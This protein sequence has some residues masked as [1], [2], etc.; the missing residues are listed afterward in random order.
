MFNFFQPQPEVTVEEIHAEFDSAEK[1]VLDEV[2]ELLNELKIPT[3]DKLERKAL[4]LK[5]LGFENTE[6]VKQYELFKKNQKIITEKIELSKKQAEL[7]RDFKFK[8]P[9]EKFITTIELE[10]ICEKY[11]LIHAPAVNYKKDIPEKN[12]LEMYKRKP[13]LNGDKYPTDFYIFKAK[14]FNSNSIYKKQLKGKEFLI[15]LTDYEYKEVIKN[16]KLADNI[17]AKK[18]GF[19]EIGEDITLYHIADLTK[20]NKEGLFICA[21][22]NHFDLSGLN[23][24]SKFGFFQ[25]NTKKL[26]DP[27]GFEF[28]KED[29]CRIITKWGTKDDQSYLDESLLNETLN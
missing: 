20:I 10:R 14:S 27:I 3:E 21:P 24:K 28:C 15:Q 7:I 1:R 26:T 2:E 29:I 16:S 17:I 13:L 6:T 25:T 11:N 4:M 23:K 8:Y 5:E 19:P 22:E 9:Q 18:I 12:V